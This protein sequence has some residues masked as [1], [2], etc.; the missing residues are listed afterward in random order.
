MALLTLL[1]LAYA[2]RFGVHPRVWA[3]DKDVVIKNP[4]R[5]Y[6]FPWAD[7]TLIAPGRTA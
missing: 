1:T 2:W 5:T 3:T 4:W 7:V 6:S